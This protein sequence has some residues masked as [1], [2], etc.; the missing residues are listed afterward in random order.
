MSAGGWWNSEIVTDRAPT[1]VEP[2]SHKVEQESEEQC[3]NKKVHSNP[4]LTDI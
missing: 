1:P 4:L 3:R 2:Y